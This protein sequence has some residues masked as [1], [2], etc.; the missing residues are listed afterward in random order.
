M[1]A[2]SATYAL[3]GFGSD[4][5]VTDI[6]VERLKPSQLASAEN[7]ILP[8]G[9]VSERGGW[10]GIG[11]DDPLASGGDSYILDSVMSAV[12][13]ASGAT[14]IVVTGR[15]SS[16]G[17]ISNFGS[18][19]QGH[20]GV[21]S[22]FSSTVEARAR[23]AYRGEALICPHDGTTS[24]RR[25]SFLTSDDQST[26]V[27][28]GT[29][30]VTDGSNQLVGAASAFTTEIEVGNYVGGAANNRDNLHRIVSV[31][32]TTKAGLASKAD[33][34]VPSVAVGIS[35]YGFIGLKVLVTDIGL[36][37]HTGSSTT[38]SGNG[39][40]WAQAGPGFGA[41]A[42]GD[43]ILRVGDDIA[44]ALRVNTVNS[45]TS[46]TV[47]NNSVGAWSDQP[48]LILRHACGTE[49]VEHDNA[50][51]V[52]GVD[53]SDD[54]VYTTPP[55]YELAHV[56]NGR[57]GKTV[58]A[59]EAMRMFEI[60]VSSPDAPGRVLG[61]RSTP[62]GLAVGK[63]DSMWVIRGQY[64]S[65][66]VDRIADL[67]LIDQRAM[68][69]ADDVLIFAAR[70]GIFAWQGGRPQDLTDGRRAEWVERAR[71]M[72]RC[73]V[74]TV[75]NHL[76]VSFEAD[77]GAECWVYDLDRGVHLGNFTSDDDG[78]TV[79]DGDTGISITTGIESAAYMD[80]ARIPG[81]PDRLLF[82]SPN[83]N[84]LQV[85][86]I[87]TTI[88]GP[89]EDAEVP[90]TNIAP[91]EVWTGTN[92]AGSISR[93]KT[94]VG[95]KLTYVCNGTSPGVVDL[96]TRIEGA[97]EVAERSFPATAGS[98][99]ETARA[100]ADSG[101]IGV[102]CRSFQVGLRRTGGTSVKRLSIREVENVVRLRRPRA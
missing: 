34:D 81:E 17:V 86:D 59:D 39:T 96:V 43:Y 20:A 45:D 94:V 41:V 54:T 18:A 64:P 70:E 1:R 36:T 72:T 35:R 76:F 8:D 26:S 90:G 49:A 37:S 30:S 29:Y 15:R 93:Q 77:T 5:V 51:W 66:Q 74:G 10:E 38:V 87:S 2:S 63:T 23:T 14:E 73:V 99:P 4:G 48:F 101:G 22:S 32:T 11:E 65:T 12:N 61:M 33:W 98:A 44:N 60:A 19:T 88:I 58:Q 97:A 53:W 92:A 28:T 55:G 82:A 68:V 27:G 62:W 56:T 79:I 71:S 85:Q 69:S 89:D 25:W 83:S 57:F 52:S 47:G 31:P 50:L 42:A 91:L 6:S 80:S 102:A 46:L 100:L 95:V 78:N 21:G 40:Q 7:M 13:P 24:I 67:G 9:V 3:D 75:R 84:V 16:D